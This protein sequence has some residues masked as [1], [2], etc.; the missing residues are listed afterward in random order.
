MQDSD[1]SLSG[2]EV[3]RWIEANKPRVKLFIVHSQN[4][5]G[6]PE[7]VERLRAAGY[8]AWAVPFGEF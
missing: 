7:M 3:I 6:T 5:C 1:S 8:P 4:P 2:M